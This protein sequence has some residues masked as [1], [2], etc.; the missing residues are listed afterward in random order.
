MRTYQ[1]NNNHA[2]PVRATSARGGFQSVAPRF[3]GSA[4][5]LVASLK[6]AQPLYVLRPELLARAAKEF[7]S[8]FPG[9]VMYAVKCNP[10]RTVLQTLYKNGVKSF[11]VASIEEAR[12]A[13]RAAPKAKLYFMHP[14]KSPEA[15]RE[16]YAVHGVRA[17]VLDTQEELYKILQ[18][19][20]LAPDL[21]LFVRLSLPKNG[22]AAIDFRAKFGV[23]PE[24]APV[25]LQKC[26]PVAAKLGICFHVG[27]QTVNPGVYARAVNIAADVMM[28]S[29][30]TV[31]VLDVGGGFP[32]TYPGQAAPPPLTQFMK[33]ITGALKKCGLSGIPLLAEPGRALVAN[34][35][36]LVVRVEQR[37]GDLL[38]INDGTY[39]GL[40]DA[41]RWLN[42]RYPVRMIRP[43]GES[44][45]EIL[46][47]RFAGPTCDSLD[48]M[49]GPF[50]LPA[51][52]KT[53]DWIEIGN[54]GAYS[55]G[56][57]GNF[58]GFGGSQTVA[59]YERSGAELPA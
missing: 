17:F 6:P 2:S 31:D 1:H 10:E 56:L 41:G 4:D 44:S 23:L 8:L 52:I 47:F 18:E 3:T 14:V 49:A 51:D 15:I 39:G 38:Y 48:M 43:A 27:T 54:T 11:D 22:S 29:G 21:E 19:T 46:P 35:T 53:G 9:E 33:S 50:D 5:E 36:S 25:L 20:D 59:L 58:N 45:A 7:T 55:R 12:L 34:S 30:V 57:R 42:L 40:F 37:R 28:K 26:R 16:A 32:A 24:D 13:R